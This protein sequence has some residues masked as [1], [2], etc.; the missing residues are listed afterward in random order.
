MQTGVNI[1]CK[2]TCSPSAQIKCTQTGQIFPSLKSVARSE[3][4]LDPNTLPEND[5]A[6]LLAV[7]EYGRQHP[8]VFN[9]EEILELMNRELEKVWIGIL[10]SKQACQD[11]VPKVN[12]L[13]RESHEIRK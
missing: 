9:W 12:A 4:F 10:P 1:P 11:L 5:K 7:E 8:H 6:Y 2:N 3:V 13:L